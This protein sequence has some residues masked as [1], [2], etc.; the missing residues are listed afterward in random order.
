MA[1]LICGAEPRPQLCGRRAVS[2][3]AVVQALQALPCR[4]LS[5]QAHV[6]WQVE[7][8]IG[9]AGDLKCETQALLTAESAP[10]SSEFDEKVLPL[11]TRVPLPLSHQHW[12]SSDSTGLV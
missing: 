8:I 7:D 3:D 9:P 1:I 11:H 2:S 10:T 6:F 5:H 12:Q 4:G